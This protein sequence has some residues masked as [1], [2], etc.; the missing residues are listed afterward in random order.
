MSS[1]WPTPR[2]LA[3]VAVATLLVALSGC[4]KDDPKTDPSPDPTT[5]SVSETPTPSETPSPSESPSQ[6]PSQSPSETASG[7]P[8]VA[9]APSTLLLPANG[10]P[11]FNET[12]HWTE[13]ATG[14][15]RGPFG[16]CQ[17]FPMQTI[18]ADKT[19]ARSYLPAGDLTGGSA[20]H[21]VSSFVDDKSASQAIAVLRSWRDRCKERLSAYGFKRVGPI[22]SVSTSKGSA[23]WYLVTY[24]K[25]NADEGRFD[26]LGVLRSGSTVELLQL[27][28]KGA[29]Y[30]YEAGKEPM[31]KALQNA[32][33]RLP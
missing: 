22:T 4:G 17:R 30:N 25:K 15:E 5:P 7:T 1:P 19:V 2:L 21:L 9:P 8:T 12:W 32:A 14:P 3:P 23:T 6:S 28:L 11:G 18:G 16:V 10:L 29:D 13:K 20:G 31:V 24:T 33:D 27:N 26:A